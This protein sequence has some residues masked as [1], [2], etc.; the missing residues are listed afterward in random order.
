[1]TDDLAF[2]ARL[3]ALRLQRG[4]S[5][6]S[7]AGEEIS[8][9]YLSR[10]ETG[11][12]QPTERVSAYLAK[13]LGVDRLALDAPPA[14]T[15][16]SSLTRALSV[17]ASSDSGESV[18]ELI[19]VLATEGTEDPS[20]RWQALWVIAGYRSRR[21]ERVEEQACLEELVEVADELALPALQC[22][23]GTRL[24]RCLRSVGEAARALELA[25]GAYRVA[26][27]AGLS[28]DDTGTALL[29]LVSADAESGRLADARA[30]AE[31]L[32]ELVAGRTDTLRAEALW[33]AATVCSRQG[34]DEA[35]HAY[36]GQAM[37]ELDSR[38]DPVLWARLR[39]AAASLYLQSR[40]ALTETART[41]LTQ[42][43]AAL[44]IVGTPLQQQEL[45]VVQAHLAF[46]EG[47]YAEARAAHEQL[48]LDNLRLTYRDR[49]RLQ[50]LDSLLLIVEGHQQQG[51]ARLKKLGEEARRAS[52]MDLAAEIWRVLAETLENTE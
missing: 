18:E 29:A 16:G 47:R 49:I 25:E 31:E 13:Q 17:A 26:K 21:G 42:A 3:K 48:D 34:D 38:V 44:E 46:E 15:S 50:T 7:L 19:D 32:V 41:C 45:L 24:A 43:E 2:G 35:V 23:S 22:R 14:A 30:H 12:R 28:V 4:L 10:L 51:R 39:L 40:P 6:A 8:T 9:G 37:Q 27:D 36:L 11:A 1:M 20:L 33:S 5:Q 52:N